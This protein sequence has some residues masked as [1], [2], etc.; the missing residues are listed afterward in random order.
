MGYEPRLTSVF[1]CVL[2]GG[3]W[4]GGCCTPP[5]G[6]FRYRPGP[7]T[8]TGQ[9]GSGTG[10]VHEAA[11]AGEV[12]LLFFCS[13]VISRRGRLKGPQRSKPCCITNH[14]WPR[15]TKIAFPQTTTFLSRGRGATL[16]ALQWFS[17]IL[18][19]RGGRTVHRISATFAKV[20]T[21]GN[22]LATCGPFW[23]G[24]LSRCLGG[25]A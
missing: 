3:G 15:C 12:F 8:L 5:R 19:G 14:R 18:G 4:D 13:F 21:R 1:A 22:G 17:V 20:P 7:E 23:V 11:A 9:L 16:A 10:A 6:V 24:G 25:V 2:V